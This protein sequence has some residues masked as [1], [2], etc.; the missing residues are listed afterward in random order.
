MSTTH[1]TVLSG[2]IVGSSKQAGPEYDGLLYTLEQG[3]RALCERFDGHFNIYRGDAFQ[4]ILGKTPVPLQATLMLRLYLRSHGLDARISEARGPID[5]YRQD[6][7]TATGAALLLSGKGLDTIKNKRLSLSL[8]EEPL[9][10]SFALNIRFVD[11][12]VSHTSQKQA[13]AL[14][15]YH[16]LEHQDHA[17]IAA[18]M[19]SSRANVTKLLNAGQYH[20][21]DEFLAVAAKEHTH[22]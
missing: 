22:E 2:D 14:Y 16:W 10:A 7:K 8:Y 20:L 17:A 1:Y 12:L 3:L 18:Q 6:V 13:Q 4:C 9:S 15:W 19:G 21:L 5:N 11:H